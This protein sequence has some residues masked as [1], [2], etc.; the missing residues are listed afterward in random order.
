M[1]I[2]NTWYVACTS[3]ELQND[4]PLGRTICSLPIAFFRTR[5]GVGAVED[6]CP[7]RGAPLSVGRV[8]DGRLQC[9]YHGLQMG[10]DG[11]VH[12]MP[13]QRVAGF[14]SVRR[15]AAV[16]R[17][18]FVWFWPG[19]FE[20]ADPERIPVLSWHD[21]P[22]WSFA[23]GVYHV[24]ADYRLLID[25]LMDLSHLHYVHRDSIGEITLDETP[26]HTEVDGDQVVTYRE[27]LDVEN[28]GV[29]KM[30]MRL[31]GMEEAPRVD[32]W[33]Y[34]RFTPPG[35]ILIDVGV[36]LPGLGGIKA[37]SDSKV[38]AVV[39][40]FITPETDTTLWYF[41]GSARNYAIGNDAVSEQTRIRLGNVFKQDEE[42]LEHQQRCLLQHPG[43]TMLNL[44]IDAGGVQARRVIDRI[45]AGERA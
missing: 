20:K 33:Q 35:R 45:I 36:A 39:V 10:C 12:S 18:G 3:D 37:P 27:M 34:S 28:I 44:N 8:V 32:R 14:P 26:C 9:G 29:W 31:A 21:D 6:F 23:G 13:R 16:E 25:N 30:T 42:M 19:D 2:Q 38:E 15:F 1:F 43:K 40:H 22:Q 41:W 17:Y 7:H 11:H 5:D 4:K 24:K